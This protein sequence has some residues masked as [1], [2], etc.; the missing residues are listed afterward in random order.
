VVGS[1]RYRTRNCDGNGT[2]V[3]LGSGLYEPTIMRCSA[4]FNDES[5]Q[6]GQSV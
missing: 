3:M 5:N 6:T 4:C 1:F 2:Q